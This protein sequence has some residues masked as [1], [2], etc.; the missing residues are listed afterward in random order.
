MRFLEFYKIKSNPKN[1]IQ[2]IYDNYQKY[3]NVVYF[4]RNG[5]EFNAKINSQFKQ[6]DERG[7][8]VEVEWNNAVPNNYEDIELK[9]IDLYYITKK[10]RKSQAEKIK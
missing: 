2:V 3:W 4:D 8:D 7:K 6:K 1:E 9:I 5:K 10:K